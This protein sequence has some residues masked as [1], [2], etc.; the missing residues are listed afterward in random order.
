MEVLFSAEEFSH[1][2][3]PE[4]APDFQIKKA[5]DM[6][7]TQSAR[8]IFSELS[9]QNA[10]NMEVSLS[11]EEFSQKFSPEKALMPSDPRSAESFFKEFAPEKAQS[12]KFSPSAEVFFPKSSQKP[13][14][15][16]HANSAIFSKTQISHPIS[17]LPILGPN[18][19]FRC[20][21]L[22]NQKTLKKAHHAKI[23]ESA[24]S[25]ALPLVAS[26]DATQTLFKSQDLAQSLVKCREPATIP[27]SSGFF[28]PEYEDFDPK[29]PKNTLF[30]LVSAGST[31]GEHAQGRDQ[32]RRSDLASP[33]FAR[34]DQRG[35]KV[36]QP[37]T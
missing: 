5:Q 24:Q 8:I 12:D 22:A 37:Q 27:L 1:Q 9:S 4:K 33:D 14:A 28:P 15:L 29:T 36:A 11:S 6:E 13:I 25:L 34:N 19:P 26:Q 21:D 17:N 32:K 18:S 16:P 20:L 10:Q 35:G 30:P 31:L 2:F 23:L 3:L 7:I